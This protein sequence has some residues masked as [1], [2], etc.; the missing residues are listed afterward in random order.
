[1]LRFIPLRATGQGGDRGH[2][3]SL[4]ARGA[5][6]GHVLCGMRGVCIRGIFIGRENST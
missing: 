2:E 3:G 5:P 1:M 4:G 6:V